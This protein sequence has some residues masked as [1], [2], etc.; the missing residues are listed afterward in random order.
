M[1]EMKENNNISS[2]CTNSMEKREEKKELTR[3]TTLKTENFNMANTSF[4]TPPPPPPATTTS[5]IDQMP[6]VFALSTTATPPPPLN[7]IFDMMP[8]DII[9]GDQKAG[10]LGFTDLLDI[11]QD[12][13][14]AASLFDWF[15]QNPIV[16]SQQQQTFV[17]S[18]ASTLPETSEV[19]NNPATPNSSASISS[20]SNEAGNDAFQQ[21][22]TGDQEEEQDHDKT[23]KQL[24]PKKKNQKRQR[25]PRFAFMTKSEVDHLDDG[26]RW[27]KYGQK[28]VK[29]SPYPRSYYRCTSAGCGVKKRVER[30]SDD[31][32]IVVTTYEGQH[33][34][35][36]PLTPRGSIGILSDST[37][38][39][40]ATSSFVI[41][42]TQYQQHAY[43]YSSS[44]SLNINTTSNTS[45]SPTFSFHQRR[46]DSPASLLRDHGLLQ[47]IVPSQ[48]RKEPKEE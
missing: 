14:A 2:V 43:L 46:S 19:L 36:S 9:G 18:P 38:F 16:G 13:G 11:N 48:M 5:D 44:P 7:S 33:I 15:A 31:S 17:P 22:K 45:F 47:D 27:R 37:G 34:H 29:N 26:F 21:V 8:F 20:S 30:S 35:P 42:Q 41:P 4:I 12:F 40:A 3:S 25:E 24:K 1:N 6:S 10:S 39:G 28:A 23:K 32:S